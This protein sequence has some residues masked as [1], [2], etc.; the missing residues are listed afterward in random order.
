MNCFPQ[1]NWKS[2]MWQTLLPCFYDMFWT[3]MW[4]RLN[5]EQQSSCCSTSFLAEFWCLSRVL[6]CCSRDS[7]CFTLLCTA[8]WLF[9]FWLGAHRP[10]LTHVF[11]GL[12]GTII[13]WCA[14]KQLQN[15]SE[16]M[17][18]TREDKNDKNKPQLVKL[19][20]KGDKWGQNLGFLKWKYEA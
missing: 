16:F 19:I 18:Q 15:A 20:D 14:M 8:L 13:V 6:A 11:I 7:C 1:N 10:R 9:T 17:I 2:E 12:Q 3:W 4:A 5:N